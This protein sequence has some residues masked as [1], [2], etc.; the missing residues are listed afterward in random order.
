MID[1]EV[2]VKVYP[3]GKRAV[4]GMSVAVP[5]GQ[6]FGFLGPNGAGKSTALKI[7]TTLLRKTSGRV[8]VAGHDVDHAATQVR[9]SIGFA[10]QEV[11]LDDLATGR[12]FLVLQG[13][14]YK[15][16]PAEAR[17]RADRL[18]E[19]MG[20]TELGGR[21]VGTYS[22]GM[23]RR[24][25]L[26][27]ALIHR[28]PLLFLDEP[29]TG[30]DP[31]SRIAIWDYLRALNREGTTIVLTTQMMEEADQL[32]QRLAIVDLGKIV[33]E[34]SPDAL[35][36]EMGGGIVTIAFHTGQA[37][38]L[39]Q[40][41]AELVRGR[42]YV[43]SAEARAGTLRVSVHDGGAAVPDLVRVLHEGG[44]PVANLSVAE[45]TLDDV[46]LK[47]TGRTIRTEQGQGD[48]MGQVMRPFMGLK[49]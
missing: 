8:I 20:L 7:M 16:P 9:R 19:M 37:D 44:V 26:L 48:E 5:Q 36:G 11:G 3:G 45:P 14:L 46:F 34:G 39:A 21:K 18:L 17:R 1:V 41:A 30:L 33:A 47:H 31:Q 27:G 22:G 4:D 42:P 12:E 25:D 32:C 29:T 35:K 2:L 38:G 49:K 40:R 24:L 28:P 6:F 13:V 10:M 15:L 43:V 23:R